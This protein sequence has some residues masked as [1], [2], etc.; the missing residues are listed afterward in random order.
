MVF[1]MASIT[2]KHIPEDLHGQLK[3]EA[4]ANFRSLNQ[5]AMA[6]LQ[7]SFEIEAALNT[8]RDQRW[9]DAALASGPQTP[10]T[11]KE[12]DKLRDRV[13]ARKKAA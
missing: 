8:K 1:R 4:S 5:E 9:I 6:R 10:L 2:L 12:M 13:L 3:R 7:R 11:R